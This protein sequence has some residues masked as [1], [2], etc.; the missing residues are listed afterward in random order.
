MDEHRSRES[1]QI[2]SVRRNLKLKIYQKGW[3]SQL[4]EVKGVDG[5]AQTSE[6]SIAL[7]PHYAELT[8]PFP[9]PTPT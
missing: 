9:A 2:K 8:K 5:A 1:R 6:C 7:F 3:F 4:E